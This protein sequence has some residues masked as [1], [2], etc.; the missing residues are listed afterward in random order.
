MQKRRGRSRRT[1]KPSTKQQSTKQLNVLVSDKYLDRIPEVADRLRSAGMRVGRVLE[2][3]GTIEG[4]VDSAG[5]ESF[6]SIEGVE[7]VEEQ[8]TYQLPPPDSDL[9]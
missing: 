2:N 4:S 9:Q 7:A 5:R 3:T 8:Q 1:K 6:Q